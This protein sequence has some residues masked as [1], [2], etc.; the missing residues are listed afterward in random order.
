LS[1]ENN[2]RGRLCKEY[3][4]ILEENIVIIEV[5]VM[6]VRQNISLVLANISPRINYLSVVS[7]LW[8]IFQCNNIRIA[9]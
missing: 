3:C 7:Q 4:V 1:V 5:C 2:K 9:K 6:A 8:Q